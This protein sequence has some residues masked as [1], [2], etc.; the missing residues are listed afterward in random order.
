MTILAKK[1]QLVMLTMTKCEQLSHTE[2]AK[3]VKGT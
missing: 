2:L 1:Q 3:V